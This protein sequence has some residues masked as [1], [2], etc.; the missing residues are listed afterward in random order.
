MR[1]WWNS[2]GFRKFRRSRMAVASAAI[3]GLY[4]LVAILV[5]LGLV[6][7]DMTDARVGPGTMPG[8]GMQQ[9]PEKRWDDAEFRVGQIAR[10]DALWSCTAP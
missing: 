2:R 4:A 1:R 8:F 5:S 9:T 7:P 10:A 6:G 3:I